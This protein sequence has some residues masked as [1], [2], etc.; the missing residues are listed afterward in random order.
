MPVIPFHVMIFELI[1]KHK[2][3]REDGGGGPHATEL[4]QS[5]VVFEEEEDLTMAYHI[6]M[7]T[8]TTYDPI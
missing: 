7:S 6:F 5:W 4:I 1:P 3:C 8:Y 2:F